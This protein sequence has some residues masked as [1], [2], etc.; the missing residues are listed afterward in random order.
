MIIYCATDINYFNLYF[1]LWA[2]Q[3]NKFYPNVPKSIGIYKPTVEAIATCNKH[4][5]ECKDITDLMPENPTRKHFYL[6]RWL[7]LPFE[8][9]DAIL[10]TNVTSLAVK[11]QDFSSFYYKGIDHL[12]ICRA[13]GGPSSK[14]R[15]IRTLGGVSAALFTPAAAKRVVEQAKIIIQDPPE[16]D[17]E[18]NMWQA[19]NLTSEKVKA[20]QQIGRL[21]RELQED[22]CWLYAGGSSWNNTPEDKIEIMRHYTNE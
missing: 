11:K 2:T 15:P 3:I 20:E 4:G 19:E 1:E 14:K 7:T 8:Q 16:S 18:M 22:T 12:R 5:I 17:H 10:E 6:L 13:K 21:D 9:G